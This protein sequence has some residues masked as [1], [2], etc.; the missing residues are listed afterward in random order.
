MNLGFI[1]IFL[2]TGNL[3]GLLITFDFQFLLILEALRTHEI[4]GCTPVK[5]ETKIAQTG[6]RLFFILVWGEGLILGWL[7][8]VIGGILLRI[9][10]HY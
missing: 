4:G 2:I 8:F 6:L 9:I 5:R 1:G 7:I 10:F 3:L